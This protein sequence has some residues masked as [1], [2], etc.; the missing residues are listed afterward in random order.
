MTHDLVPVPFGAFLEDGGVRL[1]E[2][3]RALSRGLA[4]YFHLSK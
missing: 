2:N 4:D 3:N 1:E